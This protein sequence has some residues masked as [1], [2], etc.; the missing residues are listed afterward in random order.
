MAQKRR[1]STTISGRHWKI[2][3]NLMEEYG[4]QQ[5]VLEA[6]LEKLADESPFSEFT[7]L[8]KQRALL[9]S[10]PGIVII[11]RQTIKHT[12]EGNWEKIA[13]EGLFE[14]GILVTS[15]KMVENFGFREL[16]KSFCHLLKLL[17][18]FDDII[19][20]EE[21]GVMKLKLIHQEGRTYSEYLANLNEHFFRRWGIECKT[22]ISEFFILHTLCQKMDE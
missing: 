6:A 4:S 19:P 18:L 20:E 15:G 11:P 22:E 3:E 16:V 5:K 1:I 7:E 10:Y 2:L 21:G 9:L 12:L 17:N 13:E 8:Q 14:L